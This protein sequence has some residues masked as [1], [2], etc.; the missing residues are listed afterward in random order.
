VTRYLDQVAAEHQAELEEIKQTVEYRL[1]LL[2]RMVESLERA[3]CAIMKRL[4][5][6]CPACRERRQD[7]AQEPPTIH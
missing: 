2:E 7:E 1:K 4:S 3:V 6:D 5:C